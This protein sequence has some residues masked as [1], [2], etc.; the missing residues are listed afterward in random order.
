MF[1]LALVLTPSPASDRR[2]ATGGILG[3]LVVG[4]FE[5]RSDDK[6]IPQIIAWPAR[7]ATQHEAAS[8]RREWRC[9]GRGES[10]LKGLDLGR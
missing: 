2:D 10:S 3:K 7:P 9:G 6:P 1:N 8:G 5:I 4:Q